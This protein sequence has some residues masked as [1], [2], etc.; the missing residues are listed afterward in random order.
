MKPIET[1]EALTA[2]YGEP[3]AAALK[4]ETGRL[5]DD[6]AAFI[7][8]ARFMALTTVGP[9][10]TDCSPRGD[11]GPVAHIHD[12]TT[13][14]IPDRRG[15]NRI[16]SLRNILRDPRVSL[17]FMSP[18]SSTTTRVTGQAYIT[19]EP[20]VLDTLAEAGKPPRSVIVVKIETVYFQCSRALIR[21]GLWDGV[22]A[23]RS[24]PTAGQILANMTDGAVGGDDYD[25]AWP[26]RARESLW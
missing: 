22:A 4:K 7:R 16:D 13:L 8:T 2:L 24:L 10:G 26:E 18:G 15:N 14:L 17:M 12:P 11:K 9:E 25:R 23:D 19:A 5:T 21:S 1:I 20:N 6:Y 3:S